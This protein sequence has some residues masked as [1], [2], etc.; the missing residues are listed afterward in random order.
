MAENFDKLFKTADETTQ[1]GC[2]LGRALAEIVHDRRLAAVQALDVHNKQNG[3]PLHIEITKGSTPDDY[4]YS[5][6][7][8]GLSTKELQEMAAT[9]GMTLDA[10]RKMAEAAAAGKEFP[11][12]HDRWKSKLTITTSNDHVQIDAQLKIGLECHDP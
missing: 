4:E 7:S 5:I 9:L 6:S 11:L 8:R 1:N 12:V 3:A 2:T 10:T